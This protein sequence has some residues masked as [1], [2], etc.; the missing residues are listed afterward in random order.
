MSTSEI[1]L[2]IVYKRP[3]TFGL[4]QDPRYPSWIKKYV[5]PEARAKGIDLVKHR[6]QLLEKYSGKVVFDG[7][8]AWLVFETAED[9][10]AFSIRYE[11]Y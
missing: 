4:R 2:P 7:D 5:R 8:L 1:R 3:D 9:Y 11:Y 10:T 6:N